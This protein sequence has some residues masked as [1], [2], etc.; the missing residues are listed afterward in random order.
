VK[1]DISALGKTDQF[2]TGWDKI[3]DITDYSE[4]DKR[5]IPFFLRGERVEVILKDGYELNMGYGCRTGGTR[6][7]FYVGISTGWRPVFLMILNRNSDG[8]MSIMSEAVEHWRGLGIYKYKDFSRWDY[9]R[10]T[11]EFLEPFKAWEEAR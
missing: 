4:I 8:G 5:F 9:D 6:I 1:K 3:M 7:R 2:L 10:L 11:R